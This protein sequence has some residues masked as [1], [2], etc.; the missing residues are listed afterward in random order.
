[1]NEIRRHP[2]YAQ[3]PPDSHTHAYDVALLRLEKLAPLSRQ[4]SRC[5]SS[6]RR[7]GSLEARAAATMLGWGKT[8]NGRT[9]RGSC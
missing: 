6:V 1:V 3:D 7:P 8:C 4:S 9:G 5:A 2:S